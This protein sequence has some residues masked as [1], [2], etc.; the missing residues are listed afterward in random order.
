MSLKNSPFVYQL[1]TNYV[2]SDSEILLI[3]ALLVDPAD[4]LARIDTR[5]EE[6]EVALKQLKEQRAS[7]KGP[8]HAHRALISP[9]R[10]VPDDVLV[11]IFLSCLPSEHNSLIDFAEAPLVL[12]RICRHWRSVAYSTPR[13]W[14][15]I[16]IPPLD[17]LCTP[18][19]LERSA[20]CPLSVSLFDYTNSFIPDL[21]N[22]AFVHQLLPVS[23]R[24]RHLSLTG[25][26]GFF[27]SFIRLGP[28][29]LPLLQSLW[30]ECPRNNYDVTAGLQMI[31]TL[32]DVRISAAI[33][34]LPLLLPWSRLT[35][36]RF[37]CLPFWA[38]HG[39]GGG[40]DIGGAF[41]VLRQCSNLV[42]CEIRVTKDSTDTLDTSSPVILP[43]IETLALTGYIFI[44]QNWI[45]HL[46]AP[47]LRFL[48]VGEEYE[49]FPENKIQSPL[50]DGFMSVEI[51]FARFSPSALEELFQS[52]PMIAHLRIYPATP[53]TG[54]AF[55]DG[56]LSLFG[57]P[58]ILCPM[59]THVVIT[60]PCP[61]LS[62][63]AILTFVKTRMVTST[64][65]EQFE[66][67]FDRPM[68]LDMMPELQSFISDGLQVAIEYPPPEWAFDPRNG[69][70]RK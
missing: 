60:Q 70:D 51:D 21:E 22:T 13:L 24:L 63:A 3:R 40:L 9:M 67:H 4:E 6:L 56:F 46:V 28:E 59:L 62:E 69:S 53:E 2:P 5:I 65:L 10:R 49:K 34:P 33:D 12:G 43:H 7:L 37:E 27:R 66:I 15:S 35:S 14:S 44:L 8:I 16:H 31:P 11:E 20:T 50:R 30:M 26:V 61:Q 38:D 19:W 17:Y 42:Q 68:E 45:S 39:T 18:E 47:N 57:P 36:L 54:V 29:D 1:N 25:D 32:E 48:R 23:R 52:F 64:P 58:H 41:Q 55:D